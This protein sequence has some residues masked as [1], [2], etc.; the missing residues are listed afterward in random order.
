MH[1]APSLE[2]LSLNQITTDKYNLRETVDACVRQGFRWIGAWRHK[3]SDD[4]AKAGKFIRDAG[5]K[6]SSLCRGGFFPAATSEERHKRIEDNFRAIDEAA[7][8]GTDLLVLVCGPSADRD[9][10]SAREMVID[11]I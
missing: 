3:I 8:V 1:D 4:P 6:V 7:A 2:R 9:L 5:L 11:G 10:C